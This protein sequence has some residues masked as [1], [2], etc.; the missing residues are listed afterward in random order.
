MIR[1]NRSSPPP[2]PTPRGLPVLMRDVIVVSIA[3]LLGAVLS[4]IG[5][6][7]REEPAKLNE[8]R[9]RTEFNRL[10]I[11]R[12]ESDIRDIRADIR[13]IIETMRTHKH[14]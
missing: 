1:L 9:G 14:Q 12:N 3:L 5:Y 7:F 10:R 4:G 2:P 6:L 11:E 13:R 8:T